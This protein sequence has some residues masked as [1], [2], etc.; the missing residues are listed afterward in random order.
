MIATLLIISAMLGVPLSHTPTVPT[1]AKAIDV[2]CATTANPTRCQLDAVATCYKESRCQ[3]GL[4]SS[5]G[6]GGPF[7]QQ[8]EYAYTIE[9]SLNHRRDVLNTDAMAAT[10]QWLAKRARYSH[11]VYHYGRKW[12][13]RYAGGLENHYEK[14][15]EVRSWAKS[16]MLKIKAA[17]DITASKDSTWTTTSKEYASASTQRLVGYI[18]PS[19]K[20]YLKGKSLISGTSPGK[21]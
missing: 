16:E 13:L 8:P 21:Y 15:L 4:T 11:E 5:T 17:Q 18:W 9:G 1:V 6:A 12:Y 2:V 19:S 20:S 14:W 7:Q 10:K 3:L